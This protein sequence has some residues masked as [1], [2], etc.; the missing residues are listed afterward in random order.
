MTNKTK[1]SGLGSSLIAVV[2]FLSAC[3][4]GILD[5]VKSA[6][7]EVKGSAVG[8]PALASNS[9]ITAHE[10][11]VVQFTE[12]IDTA[13]V[14]LSGTIAASI[15]TPTWKTT[16]KT[17]DTMIL[18]A[19]NAVIWTAGS[20]QTLKVNGK[21]ASGGSITTVN[22]SYQVFKGVCVS[23]PTN[24]PYP[25]AAGAIGTARNPLNTI[26]AGIAKAKSMYIDQVNGPAVV[27]VA[28]GTY[29][30]N[31]TGDTTSRIIMAEGISL[32]GGYAANWSGRDW[33]LNPTTITDDTGSYGTTDN[34]DN[35]SR[36]VDCG[37]SL[38]S[39]TKLEGF[40]INGSSAPS[41]SGTTFTAAV[42]CKDSSPTIVNNK[43]ISGGGG[44][45]SSKRYAL[46]IYGSTIAAS[47]TISANA[48]NSPTLGGSAAITNST[49]I[50]LSKSASPIIS[51]N[52]IYAGTSL[53]SGSNA[54]YGIYASANEPSPLISGN[55]IFGGPS[56]YCYAIYLDCTAISATALR[57]EN[58][59]I[60]PGGFSGGLY[61][62]GVSMSNSARIRNNILLLMGG[63]LSGTW[64]IGLPKNYSGVDIRIDNNIF[65]TDG[66]NPSYGIY[67]SSSTDIVLSSCKNNDFYNLVFSSGP[68]TIYKYLYHN[69]GPTDIT[70]I[71][72][73][74]A[75][76]NAS[77][78][79]IDDPKL[80]ANYKFTTGS[81]G[82]PSS[83]T[84][85]GLNLYSSWSGAAYK[86]DATLRPA[87]GGWSMGCY[88]Y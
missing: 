54:S 57:I 4:A 88:K 62:I 21:I 61:F 30:I 60:G 32:L 39:A 72:D 73:V 17:N 64:G 68:P 19:D 46:L 34:P 2:F 77:G 40:T 5:D 8:T 55:A 28:I 51:G 67:E 27:A 25:G 33:N 42:F 1:H 29:L 87:S 49:A 38:T 53:N 44:N 52:T 14:T 86:D 11:I 18:N 48:I 7:D 37:S 85:G 31:W 63:A 58:N 81:S 47:P 12:S 50:F 13:S 56:R 22:L 71:A 20:A 45:A 59:L 9:V 83:V 35:Y 78:N 74:N 15:P 23:L 3:S 43:I 79:I 6:I 10:T 41:G 16:A 80:D 69:T 24:S 65:Y 84:S 36:A 70:N 26:A 76:T 75:L 82:S 66:S